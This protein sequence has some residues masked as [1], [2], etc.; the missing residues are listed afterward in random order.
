MPQQ[1]LRSPQLRYVRDFYK[2][3]Q[4]VS[5]NKARRNVHFGSIDL[6]ISGLRMAS[7]R[8]PENEELLPIIAHSLENDGTFT[9]YVAARQGSAALMNPQHWEDVLM[10]GAGAVL[11]A[12]RTS[13]ENGSWPL[14]N[15][16]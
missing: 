5:S 9:D 8:E 7:G 16:Q 3:S 11:Q 4:W 1:V 12:Y 6:F 13:C 14:E 15:T 2:L 10:A